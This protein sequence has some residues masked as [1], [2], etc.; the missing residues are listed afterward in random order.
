MMHVRERLLSIRLTERL[1]K[2]PG[3]AEQLAIEHGMRRRTAEETKPSEERK[4]T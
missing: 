1:K 3:L 4:R 2:Q